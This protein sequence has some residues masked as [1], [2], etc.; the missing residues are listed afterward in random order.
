M[1]DMTARGRGSARIGGGTKKGRG[2]GKPSQFNPPRLAEEVH[3][4]LHNPQAIT[5][6]T[7]N[8]D[9]STDSPQHSLRVE[10]LGVQEATFRTQA[11]YE[12]EML[13]HEGDTR[14]AEDLLHDG[15]GQDGRRSNISSPEPHEYGVWGTRPALD[16]DSLTHQKISEI[17][18]RIFGLES[19]TPIMR[20]VQTALDTGENYISRKWTGTKPKVRHNWM[21][22]S[23]LTLPNYIS[24]CSTPNYFF[25]VVGRKVG[26]EKMTV[27]QQC[28]FLH[29][30]FCLDEVDRKQIMQLY[31][32]DKESARLLASTSSGQREKKK[33]KEEYLRMM[34]FMVRPE[35]LSL[36]TEALGNYESREQLDKESM[37]GRFDPQVGSSH[38]N[39]H[40]NIPVLFLRSKLV[41]TTA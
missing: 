40:Y 30:C 20:G 14:Q 22:V 36:M 24:K 1:S 3:G 18:H 6:T 34:L 31:F 11:I 5:E 21:Y 4:P 41:H 12:D 39:A 19:L 16:K 2:K 38:K 17:V 26:W 9:G 25:V 15:Q 35:N 7:S 33:R 23:L 29:C 32:A 28:N 8:I 10:T 37:Y 27:L 13:V